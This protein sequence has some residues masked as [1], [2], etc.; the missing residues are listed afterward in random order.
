MK[1]R[2]IPALIML[3]ALVT[4]VSYNGQAMD[5]PA[6]LSKILPSYLALKDA[7]VSSDAKAASAKAEELQ[8]AIGAVNTADLSASDK[9]VYTK[10]KEKL[11]FDA[12]HISESKD[13]EH[14]RGHFNTLSANMILLAKSTKLSAQPIYQEYCPMKKASWLSSENAVKNPYYGSQM[15]TCGKV[16]ETIK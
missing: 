5:Q 1:T 8:K 11:T 14:Q 7:L 12:R 13:I 9:A 16:T 2:L 6:A 4:G 10:L 15:L 3:I